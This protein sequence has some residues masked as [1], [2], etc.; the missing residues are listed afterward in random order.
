MVGGYSDS[1]EE[2]EEEARGG[3]WCFGGFI[4][5]GDAPVTL[6]LK[7]LIIMVVMTELLTVENDL[8]KQ[9]EKAS[10]T[11]TRILY[12]QQWRRPRDGSFV[13]KSWGLR[14][15]G[16]SPRQAEGRRGGRGEVVVLPLLF[17]TQRR[18]RSHSRADPPYR[19]CHHTLTLTLS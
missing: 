3:C 15:G 18:S 8:M 12:I 7:M 6:L 1:G 13:G 11:V 2:E 17:N 19:A 10:S 16:E 4:C 14:R 9:T 5:G